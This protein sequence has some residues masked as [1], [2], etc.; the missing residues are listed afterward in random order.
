[1]FAMLAITRKQKK[2][3]RKTKNNSKEKI[4]KHPPTMKKQKANSWR[5]PPSFPCKKFVLFHKRG[6]SQGRWFT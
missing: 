4:Y 2:M 6:F 5:P 1:R 3:R